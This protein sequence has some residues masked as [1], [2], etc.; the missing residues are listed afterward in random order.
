MKTIIVMATTTRQA[1]INLRRSQVAITPARPFR[2]RRARPRDRRNHAV[3]YVSI[4]DWTE[5]R[6][7]ASA[8][9]ISASR[10]ASFSRHGRL[11]LADQAPGARL[12]Q[13][14]IER[15]LHV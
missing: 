12:P 3:L 1:C 14:E 13:R 10:R 15:R 2:P 5:P 8:S 9:Q 7:Y 11:P 6:G 4:D